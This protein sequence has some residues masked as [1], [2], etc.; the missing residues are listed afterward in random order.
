MRALARI[1]TVLIGIAAFAARAADPTEIAFWESVRDTKNPAEL[2][3]YIRQY[4]D[5]A[6]K[7]LA[8]ARLAALGEKTPTPSPIEPAIAPPIPIGEKHIPTAGDVWTYRLSYPRIR[9]QWGKTQKPPQTY[10]VTATQSSDSA[11]ADELSIDGGAPI[12]AQHGKGAVLLEQGAAI[13][14]PYFTLLDSAAGT[15]PLGAVK[16]L[17]LACNRAYICTAKVRL[18]GSEALTVA[19]GRFMATKYVVDETW[20]PV[21]GSFGRP[22]DTAQMTGGRTLMIW[23]APQVGRAVKYES[24]ITVGDLP[25][26]EDPNFDLELVSFR[27][28]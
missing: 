11:V 21:S 18:A 14:S 10:V 23:Y 3:A 16:N 2:R 26:I 7:A 28:K 4:P 25:P 13:F 22:G 12:P 9:G 5:G 15:G 27:L 8:E 24:R 1:V 20:R 6:F 19:A 17:E